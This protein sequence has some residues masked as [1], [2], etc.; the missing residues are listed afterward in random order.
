MF[1]KEGE[2]GTIAEEVVDYRGQSSLDFHPHHFGNCEGILDEDIEAVV[3]GC[4]Q[5]HSVSKSRGVD[6]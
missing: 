6:Q 5:E 1:S 2:P 4:E 3:T